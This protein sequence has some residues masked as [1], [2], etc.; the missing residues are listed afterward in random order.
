VA[1]LWRFDA[2]MIAIVFTAFVASGSL[3]ATLHRNK[4]D[5]NRPPF[6]PQD[7]LSSGRAQGPNVA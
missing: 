6:L 5:A 2:A 4:S 1:I 7:A 3:P